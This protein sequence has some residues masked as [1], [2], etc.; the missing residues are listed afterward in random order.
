MLLLSI[1]LVRGTAKPFNPIN[2]AFLAFV[3]VV[4]LLLGLAGVVFWKY[5]GK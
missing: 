5:R 3:P 2:K 1:F 4:L